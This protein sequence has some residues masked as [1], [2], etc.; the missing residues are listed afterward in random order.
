MRTEE[1]SK[2]R[3]V[4]A[5]C[6]PPSKQMDAKDPTTRS[7]ATK[8]K[9]RDR[10]KQKLSH[11]HTLSLPPSLTLTHTHALAMD[12]LLE[13]IGDGLQFDLTGHCVK[14]RSH[15]CWEEEEVRVCV[16]VRGCAWM[17]VDVK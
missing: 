9:N 3:I 15:G 14:L 4:H 17:C 11:T 2:K 8:T 10:Q 16:D 12:S 1:R 13:E 6:E 5:R 7:T